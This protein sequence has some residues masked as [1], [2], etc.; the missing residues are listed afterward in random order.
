M[1]YYIF[2]NI[3]KNIG[4]NPGIHFLPPCSA[5]AHNVTND[6]NKG[7]ITTYVTKY[8]NYY[9]RAPGISY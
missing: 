1:Y 7:Q 9:S 2:P 5:H 4:K 3:R 8:D 6:T